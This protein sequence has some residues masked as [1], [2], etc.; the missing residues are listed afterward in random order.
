MGHLLRLLHQCA[1]MRDAEVRAFPV[2]VELLIVRPAM[3]RLQGAQNLMTSAMKLM[4]SHLMEVAWQITRKEMWLELV[5]SVL[6]AV[7]GQMVRSIKIGVL[8]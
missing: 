3:D 7:I 8:Y 5:L 4:C 1:H 6:S 2:H